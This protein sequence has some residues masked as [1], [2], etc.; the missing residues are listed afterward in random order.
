M[1]QQAPFARCCARSTWGWGGAPG[2]RWF[3]FALFLAAALAMGAASALAGEPLPPVG[4]DPPS[5]AEPSIRA[6]GIPQIILLA[7][8][9]AVIFYILNWV[10]LDVRLVGTNRSFWSAVVL[11]G[12]LAGLAAAVLT[13]LFYIGLPLGAI[14]FGGAAVVYA[15]HRNGLVTANL[16]VLSAAHA[17]R[18]LARLKGQRPTDEVGPVTGAGRDIIF[19]G[20]DDLPIRPEARTQIEGQASQEV[21]RVLHEAIAR[22]ASLLG[23]VMRGPKAQVRLAIDGEVTDGGEIEPPVSGHVMAAMKRLAGLNVEEARKP[24]EGRLR[25]VVGG[26]TFEL[27]VKAS[28]SVRGEQVAVRVLDLATGQRRLEDLGLAAAQVEALARALK[29]QPGLVVVSGPKDSG[30]TTTLHT[31]LRSLDRYMY[32]CVIFEP[33]VDLEVENVQ[34]LALNQEDGAA[35]AREV[36]RVVRMQPDVVACDSLSAP[37]AARALLETVGEHRALAGLRAADAGQ[38]LA[39][40]LELAGSPEPV[41]KALHLVANQRLVRLLCPDCKE[42]YRPNPDFLRKA[43]LASRKVDLLFRAPVRIEVHKGKPVICPRCRNLRYAGR[44]GLFELM[45]IDQEARDLIARGAGVADVRAA[46]RKRGMT[47]LQ[48]EGLRLVIDGATSIEEVLRVIKQ[49]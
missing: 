34:H 15:M 6:I 45:P 14:V 40:L 27:R 26:L 25:A 48:E 4:I 35:A 37:E 8:F 16:T 1:K 22:R 44:T 39:R 2:R 36:Q 30:L 5:M 24:Q 13:P 46:A 20:L 29:Q 7:A 18:I 9:A 41:A 31:C 49:A 21:E 42:S 43:N 38:A 32:N 47:N 12:G 28:G 19:M 23:L 3:I 33:H 11:A 10:F 17:R